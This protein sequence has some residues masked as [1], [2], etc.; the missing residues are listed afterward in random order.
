MTSDRPYR[1]S[2]SFEFAARSVMSLAGTQFDPE[3][4]NGFES[5]K[6]AIIGL[7]KEMGKSPVPRNSEVQWLERAG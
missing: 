7:L 4:A 5:R 3:V 6:L 1:K 2:F